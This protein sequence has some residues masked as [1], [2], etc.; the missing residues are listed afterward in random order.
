MG[1]LFLYIVDTGGLS[2]AEQF[3]N[4]IEQIENFEKQHLKNYQNAL[5]EI[6]NN[7][8][9]S[10]VDEDILSLVKEPPLDSMDTIKL[11]LIELAKK[12]NI[13]L[14]LTQTNELISH[15]RQELL[16]SFLDI[17]KIR[18]EILIKKVIE[19]IPNRESEILEFTNYDLEIIN[20][21]IKSETNKILKNH[22][23]NN[24]LEKMILIYQNDTDDQVKNS[25][26]KDFS[27]Y[28]NTTYQKKVKQNIE[29]KI[30]VKDRTLVN[31]T[32]EQGER[33]LFTKSNS[34]IFDNEKVN[35]K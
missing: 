5:I 7:N 28:M 3:V 2:M 30:L 11:K 10:L 13:V 33:Y 29:I 6:V 26:K 20:K 4:D 23:K 17:K 8:T 19:F 12:K 9:K 15:F 21:K 27:K 18:S 24:L 31:G 16:K 35:T 32:A 34:H 1:L 25:I 22:I 14:E